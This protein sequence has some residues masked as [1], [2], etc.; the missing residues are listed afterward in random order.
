MWW[1]AREHWVW[2][3]WTK[4]IIYLCPEGRHW[5][6]EDSASDLDDGAVY[7][8][9]D[10]D[11]EEERH[12]EETGDKDTTKIF[13]NNFKNNRLSLWKEP[14]ELRSEYYVENNMFSLWKDWD[15]EEKEVSI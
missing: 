7:S 5:A 10:L 9:N 8:E 3:H 15:P 11:E 4:S 1:T 6:T 2:S 14:E 12:T 13:E